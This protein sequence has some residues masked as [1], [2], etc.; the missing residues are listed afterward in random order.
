MT[1]LKL[2]SAKDDFLSSAHSLGKLV[3][4]QQFPE[5]LN[6]EL[7]LKFI[8]EIM[9]EGYLYYDPNAIKPEPTIKEFTP[10]DVILH[11]H[12]VEFPD[13][14]V[15]L[16]LAAKEAL[17]TGRNP[18]DAMRIC[19][20]LLMK[21]IQNKKLKATLWSMTGAVYPGNLMVDIET[22]IKDMASH[23]RKELGEI[24]YAESSEELAALLFQPRGKK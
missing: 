13:S 10:M 19:A 4:N 21:R 20:G 1:L 16:K 2:R 8:K 22:A 3:L 9:A 12:Y 14:I 5:P 15:T 24:I 7:G 6:P 23:L 18:D 11:T 17:L